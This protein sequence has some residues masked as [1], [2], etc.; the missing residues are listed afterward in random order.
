[1]KGCLGEEY[2]EDARGWNKV[3]KSIRRLENNE[4]KHR[5][6]EVCWSDVHSRPRMSVIYMYIYVY[7]VSLV[8]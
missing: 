8:R 1:M 2:E 5:S 6:N 4:L 3:F 7:F